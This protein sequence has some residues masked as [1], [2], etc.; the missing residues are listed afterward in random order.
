MPSSPLI[1]CLDRSFLSPEENLACDQAL[2][3]SC[4]DGEH[5]GVLR[6]WHSDAYFVVAGYTNRISTEVDISA[7]RETGTPILRRFSGGGSIVQGPGSLNY[8]LVI[9]L[10]DHPECQ[11]IGGTNVFLMKQH[12]DALRTLLGRSVQFNGTSDLT[13]RNLK[14]S[15]NAQRRGRHCVIVHG[16]FLLT[17]DLTLISRLL[18]S[19][20]TPPEYRMGR[21]HSEFLTNINVEAA[22]VKTALQECWNAYSRLDTDLTGRIQQLVRTRYADPEWTFKY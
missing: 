20:S 5:T 17:M 12:R 7:C 8:C 10:D 15:G 2:F 4:E 19:P 3:E 9:R 1:S 14:F 13:I 22:T 18:P 21:P 16:T 6:F 11:T